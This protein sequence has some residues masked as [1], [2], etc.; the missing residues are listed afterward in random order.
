MT[1]DDFVKTV[2]TH[3]KEYN[4]KWNIE[5]Y[6]GYTFDVYLS[7]ES[8]HGISITLELM[9]TDKYKGTIHVFPSINDESK[10]KTKYFALSSSQARDLF[11]CLVEAF[12]TR[13][14]ADKKDTK[15]TVLD[16]L[17]RQR[18]ILPLVTS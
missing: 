16:L 10:Y 1:D 12:G 15:D 11:F 17:S 6:D 18:R 2:C 14:A 8:I 5:Y 13:I 3:I 7:I 4:E 9:N